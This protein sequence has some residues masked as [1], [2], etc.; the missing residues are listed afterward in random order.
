MSDFY[1]NAGDAQR[2]QGV[3]VSTAT[4]ASGS[5]LTFN[6]TTG[7]W[8]PQAN[9]GG[10]GGA[11]V[12]AQYLA[13][14]S[15][16]T[17]TN[18]RVFTPGTGLK[19]V[20]AGAGAAYTLNLDNNVLATISGS[21]FAQLT[22]SLQSI[23]GGLS[24]LVGGSGISVTTQS[25][26]QIVITAS[27]GGGGAPASAQYL[28][29][30]TDGTLTAE[31]A[32]TPGTGLFAVDAGANSTYTL[33]ANNNVL[34][35]ITGSKFSGPVTASAG[36]SAAQVQVGVG[37]FVPG[38]DT[39]LFASGTTG[40]AAGNVNRRVS[41]FASDLFVSGVITGSLASSGLPGS[42]QA[43][44]QSF[45]YDPTGAGTL[46]LLTSGT[47]VST[48]DSFF[49]VHTVKGRW[50]TTGS[51]LVTGLLFISGA[52]GRSYGVDA[53]LTCQHTSTIECGRWKLSGHMRRTGG[54]M[55]WVAQDTALSSSNVPALSGTLGMSGGNVIVQS[56]AN[57]GTFHWGAELRVQEIGV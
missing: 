8:E 9:S 37:A 50:Q 21:T 24:Y 31:R 32:F 26:G 3:E 40:L 29:L 34:A 57:S 42:V 25:N 47:T 10:G 38:L 15:D 4:P 54:N 16:G 12:G 44:T 55:L 53:F 5:V 11:P 43:L 17:L 27:A 23:A 30:A 45:T 35:T 56:T 18:E 33:N 13:L 36:V 49:R 19:S 1:S 6:P 22:G 46:S 41:V 28:T 51:G 52:N 7:R 14:A 20:D 39:V 48:F 2:I